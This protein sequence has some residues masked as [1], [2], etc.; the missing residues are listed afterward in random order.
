MCS[1]C[2]RKWMYLYPCISFYL[3]LIC[4]SKKFTKRGD[5]CVFV[6]AALLLKQISMIVMLD[7][8]FQHVSGISVRCW[9]RCSNI[10]TQFSV[11]C[12]M[13]ACTGT[14]FYL[15]KPYFPILLTKQ[16][17]YLYRIS[18][19]IFLKMWL[20][21]RKY[22]KLFWMFLNMFLYF[23]TFHICLW[24]VFCRSAGQSVL[25]WSPNRLSDPYCFSIKGRLQDLIRYSSRHSK[26]FNF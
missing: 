4:F 7:T 15:R 12:F 22:L 13:P 14:L 23:W 5:C 6:L 21:F 18:C 10:M 1:C 11:P 26:K 16:R 25:F 9:I 3:A 2:L 20:Y 17:T 24:F 19:E 8:M